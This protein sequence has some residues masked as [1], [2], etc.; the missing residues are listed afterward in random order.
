MSKQKWFNLVLAIAT[1]ILL[2][3]SF[4]VRSYYG[5]MPCSVMRI[6]GFCCLGVYL[7][8]RNRKRE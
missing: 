5:E 1:V 6:V 2:V 7:Y 8:R 4:P 3:G